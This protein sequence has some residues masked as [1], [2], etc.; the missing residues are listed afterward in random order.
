MAELVQAVED[1]EYIDAIVS[2]LVDEV[3]D[4]IFRIVGITDGIRTAG[5]HLEE[6]VRC[7]FSH[8]AKAFP[9]AFIKETISHV[10]GRAA[11]VFKGEELRYVD[12]GIVDG[13]HD[14]MGPDAGREQRLV[15]I[16]V[17]GIHE[18]DFLLVHDPLGE[19]LRSHF[20]EQL[21]GAFRCF[22]LVC[23]EQRK[24]IEIRL[25]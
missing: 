17:R 9:W 7:G 20:I 13:I 5:Q 16:T 23:I 25:S 14:V 2:R 6:D 1:T 24:R 11:P 15:R 4:H 21:P 8:L 3:T 10:E 22:D 18:H 19:F 12:S